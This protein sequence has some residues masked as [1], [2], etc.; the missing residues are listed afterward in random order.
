MHGCMQHTRYPEKTN[1]YGLIVFVQVEIEI[2]LLLFR[3]H[4]KTIAFFS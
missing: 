3:V 2:D 1:G 4:A